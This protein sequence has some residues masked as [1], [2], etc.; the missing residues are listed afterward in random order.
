MGGIF[1][2]IKDLFTGG[3]GSP[4]FEGLSDKQSQQMINY[5]LANQQQTRDILN[6]S[7]SGGTQAF[8]AQQALLPMAYQSMGL[9]PQ[10]DQRGN[11]V[12]YNQGGPTPEQQA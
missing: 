8:Q 9:T 4:D 5:Q 1:G 11:I 7:I 2:G 10:Y 3:G 12:G 6:Q